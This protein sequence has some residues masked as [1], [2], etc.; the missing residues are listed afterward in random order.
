MY[1]NVNVSNYLYAENTDVYKK[2]LHVV[3][4]L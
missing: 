1:Q 3:H 4:D 2:K